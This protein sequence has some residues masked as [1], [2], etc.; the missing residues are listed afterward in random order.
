MTPPLPATPRELHRM[1][2]PRLAAATMAI[3][4]AAGG[5]AYMI[6]TARSEDAALE[7]A[8]AG[9]RHFGSPAMQLLREG[10]VSDRHGALTRLL[11]Q[12]GFVGIRVF[13]RDGKPV[14]ET[15]ASI[16]ASLIESARSHTHAW[17]AAGTVHR[18]WIGID[19]ER[20]IQAVL[21]LVGND[22]ALVG[23]LEGVYRLDREVLQHQQEQ[24][25]NGALMAIAAV[26]ATALL[27]YPLLLAMLRQSTRLSHRLLQSNLSLI[28]SLGNAVAK[29]DSGTDAHNYRVTLYAVAVAEAMAVPAGEISHLVVGA[30]LHDIGKIGIPDRILLAP[31]KLSGEEFELMKSHVGVGLDI[32]AGIPWLQD[33]ASVIRHHHE[34]FDGTG[35]PDGLRGEAIPRNAR[36]FSVVD[37]F[38]ALT[39]ARPYKA[40]MLLAEALAILERDAGRHFDPAVVA[41]FKQ[42]ASTLYDRIALAGEA[43]L[44]LEMRSV[45]FRYFQIETAPEG[46]AP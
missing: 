38:D 42:I 31:G 7:L 40:A 33:A 1:L 14:F 19:G 8:S 21:P 45:L 17:P 39:S 26:I 24:I 28:R 6:E 44:H 5:T 46:A 35:Y 2:A 43:D 36:I 15:W 32:V 9:A 37:V 4:L 12:T 18:S 20:L 22:R 25:R 23:Y 34:W 41:A 27:L 16:P 3:G 10:E 30:F 29:R 13:D 11:N